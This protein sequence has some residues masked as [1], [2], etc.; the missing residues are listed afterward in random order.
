MEL[1]VL[2]EQVRGVPPKQLFGER[3]LVGDTLPAR[4]A[5]TPKLQVPRPESGVKWAIRRVVRSVAVQ[6]W[7]VDV[8]Y[9]P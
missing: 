5:A 3:H 6:V 7:R 4:L 2:Y 9:H 1:S 8:V